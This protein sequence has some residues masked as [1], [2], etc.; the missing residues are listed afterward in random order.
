MIQKNLFHVTHGENKTSIVIATKPHLTNLIATLNEKV[1]D[2]KHKAFYFNPQDGSS[3]YYSPVLND[4]KIK[5]LKSFILLE[6][7]LEAANE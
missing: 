1:K 3:F 2:P 6:N 5:S 7:P 4:S